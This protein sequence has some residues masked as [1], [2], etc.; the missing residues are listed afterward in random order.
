MSDVQVVSSCE[1]CGAY[2]EKACNGDGQLE[3]IVC[4]T[5]YSGPMQ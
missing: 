3:C 2:T 5:V 4:H 1:F